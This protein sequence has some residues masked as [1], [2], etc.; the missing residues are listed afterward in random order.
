MEKGYMNA[1]LRN[2]CRNAGV[3]T[4]ALYFFFEDK[5]DLFRA[6][7]KETID[8][9]FQ[10]MQKHSWTFQKVLGHIFLVVQTL[11]NFY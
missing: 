5:A 3:T 10:I 8:V 6:I 1:S 4:G 9:F 7:T 11:I 2:I